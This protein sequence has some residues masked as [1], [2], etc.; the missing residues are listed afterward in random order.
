MHRPPLSSIE[1]AA[2]YDERLPS[3]RPSTSHPWNRLRQAAS[4]RHTASLYGI[5]LS[6][7]LLSSDQDAHPASQ[8]PIPAMGGEPPVIPTHTGAA[9]KASVA[10]Q[11]EL[12]ARQALQ[13]RWLQ[14]SSSDEDGND[15]ESGIGISAAIALIEPGEAEEENVVPAQDANISRIDFITR[16]PPELA[17]QILSHLDATALARVSRVCRGW[18]DVS[19][20]GH[21]WR[22]SCLRQTSMAYA[23]SGFVKPGTGLGVP[24]VTP[25]CDWRKIYQ[26]KQELRQRWKRGKA[27]P[28]YLNGHTNSVYCLQFDE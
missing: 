24:T 27:R 5:S 2:G 22:E 25:S 8:V 3:T 6:Q 20:S 18:Y 1:D 7:D 19:S 21:I 9:A 4:S 13:Y 14:P 26:V 15:R 10:M 17:I 11:N 28:V 16:L 12:M 23:A